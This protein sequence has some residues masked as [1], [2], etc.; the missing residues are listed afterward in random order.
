M[1][2]IYIS[3]KY[4]NNNIN[5]NII[6][7]YQYQYEYDILVIIYGWWIDYTTKMA[8]SLTARV[9]SLRHRLR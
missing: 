9:F 4:K 1:N 6:C 7:E 3:N 8:R 2:I 5:M